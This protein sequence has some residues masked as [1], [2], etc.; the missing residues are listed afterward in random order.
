MAQQQPA[1]PP[2][3]SPAVPPPVQQIAD[4]FGVPPSRLAVILPA[5]LQEAM[6]E[7]RMTRP[8]QGTVLLWIADLPVGA[9]PNPLL[10]H[11]ARAEDFEAFP[12]RRAQDVAL[13]LAQKIRDD[14]SK[15]LKDGDDAF[16]PIV[17]SFVAQAKTGLLTPLEIV[18]GTHLLFSPTPE[19]GRYALCTLLFVTPPESRLAVHNWGFVAADLAPPVLQ[20]R[21]AQ[22]ERL[23]SPLFPGHPAFEAC[24]M[25]LYGASGVQGG[26]SRSVLS[27][28]F[29]DRDSI[30]L[31]TRTKVAGAGILPVLQAPD[32]T[33]GVDMS[34]VEIAFT[35]L[36]RENANLKKQISGLDRRNAPAN[37]GNSGNTSNPTGYQRGRGNYQRGRSGRGRARGG[38]GDDVGE[39]ASTEEP[40]TVVEAK[41]V[42]SSDKRSDFWTVPRV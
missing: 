40:R 26:S 41:P 8:S 1:V 3:I 19:L 18:I 27:E 37:N 32:G 25:R 29:A 17:A 5:T 4:V 28:L 33:Y 31:K 22:I 38:A 11:F 10:R 15:A 20:A 7:A 24:N 16:K 23:A 39:D 14:F 2:V 6:E 34:P 13:S 36:Q 12:W 30:P 9:A 21:G 42:A 35:A